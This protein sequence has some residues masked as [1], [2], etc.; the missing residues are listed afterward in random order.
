MNDKIFSF[1]ILSMGNLAFLTH[2]VSRGQ[3]VCMMQTIA[4][5]KL[6]NVY[7][8]KLYSKQNKL[9]TI[10]KSKISIKN[11]SHNKLSSIND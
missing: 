10:N 6:N 7:Y 5:S 3:G 8:R 4:T 2:K 11:I 9:F 1:L